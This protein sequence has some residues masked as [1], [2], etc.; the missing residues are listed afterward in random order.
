M[1]DDHDLKQMF[2][3]AR[4]VD[5]QLAPEFDELAPTGNMA[6]RQR[7]RAAFASVAVAL[8]IAA[9]GL[10]FWQYNRDDGDQMGTL[11]DPPVPAQDDPNATAI[12]ELNK[13]CDSLLAA[14][15]RLEADAAIEEEMVWP[16][17]T[18]SLLAAGRA[19]KR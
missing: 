1:P 3:A 14:V 18:N 6:S 15:D 4:E 10:W 13:A 2:T 7:L 5:E 12:H 19:A 16:T 9:V 8:L 17:E 11:P